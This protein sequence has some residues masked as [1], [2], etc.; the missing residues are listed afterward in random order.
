MLKM[1]EKQEATIKGLRQALWVVYPCLVRW[2]AVRLCKM[3]RDIIRNSTE[4]K[5]TS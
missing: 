2:G 1:I 4:G 5:T 3:I